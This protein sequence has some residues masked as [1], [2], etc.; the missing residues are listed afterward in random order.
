ML[1]DVDE[2]AKSIDIIIKR[3]P[4]FGVDNILKSAHTLSQKYPFHIFKIRLT[5]IV[6]KVREK[7]QQ[8][9]CDN[10]EYNKHHLLQIIGSSLVVIRVRNHR[11]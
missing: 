6:R 7:N 11:E 10:D 9:K 3:T 2:K 8:Q 1:T 4:Q 5:T